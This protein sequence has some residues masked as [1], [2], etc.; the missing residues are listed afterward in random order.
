MGEKNQTSDAC[1]LPE[2]AHHLLQWYIS[3]W[4]GK[5]HG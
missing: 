5:D 1:C 3:E 2:D 4:N